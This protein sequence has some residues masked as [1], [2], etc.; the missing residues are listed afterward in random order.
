MIS[1]DFNIDLNEKFRFKN[2]YNLKKK[3]EQLFNVFNF[4]F[5]FNY[6]VFQ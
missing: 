4:M 1:D 2:R 6:S 3:K 5:Q